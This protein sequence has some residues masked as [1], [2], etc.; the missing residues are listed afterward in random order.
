MC[1]SLQTFREVAQVLKTYF[2]LW[3]RGYGYIYPIQACVTSFVFSVLVTKGGGF[4]RARAQWEMI[5]SLRVLLSEG[6]NI[7]LKTS[8][9]VPPKT[10]CYQKNNLSPE[11]LWLPLLSLIP[12]PVL[13]L[14]A[15]V[16]NM[17]PLPPAP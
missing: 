2:I 15:F 3:L 16:N 6:I 14:L 8:Q 12:F 5:R 7:V 9:L 11:S 13:L 4:L 10:T 17:K 1:V